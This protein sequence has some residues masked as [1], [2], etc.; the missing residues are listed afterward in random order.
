MRRLGNRAARSDHT[1]R[2][3][4]YRGSAAPTRSEPGMR[5]NA[6]LATLVLL[7]GPVFALLGQSLANAD[8]YSCDAYEVCLYENNDFNAGE[9]ST[10]GVRQWTLAD[11]DYRNDKWYDRVKPS[12]N[13]TDVLDNEASS[14]RNRGTC[15]VVLWQNVG[16]SGAASIFK[17]ATQDNNLSNNNIG[18]NRASSHNWCP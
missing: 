12:H 10:Y 16:F 8:V 14:V 13:L 11:S 4:S 3:R 15:S 2:E 6:L 18:D 1:A 7:L 9:H 5:R 17:A